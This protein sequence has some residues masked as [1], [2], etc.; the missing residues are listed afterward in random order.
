[1]KSYPELDLLVAACRWTFGGD[2]EAPV[3]PSNRIDWARLLALA[4]RHRVEALAWNCLNQADLPIPPGI[5]DEFALRAAG[6]VD[7]NLRTAMECTRLNKAFGDAGIDLLF[8]KGLTLGALGYA[9][10]FLKMGWDIDLLVAPD[11]IADATALLASLG[12]LPRVPASPRTSAHIFDWHQR[13]K[14]SAWEKAKGEFH[15]D[16]HGRLADHPHLIPSLGMSSPRQSVAIASGIELPTL[17]ADV[18]F[19]YL[20]VHGASSAWFRLKWITDLAALIHR[21]SPDEIDRLYRRSQELG[22]GRA[23]G[24]A[25]MLADRLYQPGLSE[26]LR[27]TLVRDRAVTWLAN[28]AMAQLRS[29]REPTER[30]LGTLT[31]HGSQLFLQPGVRPALGELRRQIRDVVNWR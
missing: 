5:A 25:L 7:R 23:A 8:V 31:I 18:L 28:A 24:Q 20:C 10:P 14:E 26:K 15:L 17:A 11:R 3:E 16:L 2:R 13:H 22:A 27:A 12:Y 21:A 1:M 4:S 9:S 19:A 29:F 30:W 6:I